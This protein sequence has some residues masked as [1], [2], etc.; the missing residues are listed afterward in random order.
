[1]AVMPYTTIRNL[2]VHLKYKVSK[3]D[4]AECVYRIPCKNCQKVY[5]GETGRSFEVCIKKHWKEEELHEGKN[6][7]EAPG[8]NQRAHQHKNLHHRLERGNSYRPRI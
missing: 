6:T 4:T 1:M 2:L 3:D 8:N 7:P 5:I